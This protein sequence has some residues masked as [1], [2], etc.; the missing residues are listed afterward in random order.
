MTFISPNPLNQCLF[1]HKLICLIKIIHIIKKFTHH[2][3]QVLATPLQTLTITPLH[4]TKN[5]NKISPTKAPNQP[6]H[7]QT[8]PPLLL[9]STLINITL[10]LLLLIPQTPK[11]QHQQHSQTSRLQN[12][13]FLHSKN[14]TN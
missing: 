10:T 7:H 9:Q 11:K 6:S 4:L 8:S 5:K 13:I 2:K 3:F 12:T 1:L 14:R